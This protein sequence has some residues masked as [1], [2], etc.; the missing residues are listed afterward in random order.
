MLNYCAN[1]AN[2][3]FINSKLNCLAAV[4]NWARLKRNQEKPVQ[5]EIRSLVHIQSAENQYLGDQLTKDVTSRDAEVTRTAESC[6]W[7]LRAPDRHPHSTTMK[8]ILL[9]TIV[10]AVVL[11]VSYVSTNFTFRNYYYCILNMHYSICIQQKTELCIENIQLSHYKN[12][13]PRLIY[14]R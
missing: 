1:R 11:T 9:S 4:N 2:F 13:R 14:I 10:F 12:F 7:C 6:Q 8:P 3:C 5:L